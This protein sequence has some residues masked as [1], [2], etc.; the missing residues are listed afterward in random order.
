MVYLFNPP[1]APGLPIVGSAD[2]FPI[3]RV[4]CVGRNYAA[5]AREMGADPDSEPPVFFMKPAD[6]VT[7]DGAAIPYPPATA[8]LHYEIE[9]VVALMEGG[10]AVP[11]DRA[12]EC[13]FG[14]AVGIDLTRRDLQNAAKSAGG[15]WD[16]AKGFDKSAPCSAVHPVAE[17]GHPKAG[18]IRLRV[19]GELRQEGDLNQLIWSVPLVIHHLSNLVSLAPGDLIFTGT[20]SGVGPTGIG[21]VLDGEVDGVGTLLVTIV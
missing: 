19:N 13:V 6:A 17:I 4:Y 15:P 14:Y 2:L 11:A 16:M 21:D 10:R 8:D 20:P 7:H 9:L 5:H 1:P 12:L 3:H 18:G